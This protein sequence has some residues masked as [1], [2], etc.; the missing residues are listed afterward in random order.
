MSTIAL[1]Q[2]R[3]GSTRLPGK[4]LMDIAGQPMLAHVVE[5][6]LRARTLDGLVI[7]TTKNPVDEAIVT[8]ARRLGVPAFRGSEEDVLDRYYRAAKEHDASVIVRI[9]ADCPLIDP[10]VV[11]FVVEAFR[12]TSPDYASNILERTFPQ[13][14][15]T[16][17]VKLEAL[18]RAW[19]EASKAYQRA[20]VTPYIY[21]HPERFR[22]YSVRNAEDLS[23]HRWTVDTKEDLEFVRE[24]YSR[25][26]SG[27]R[28][29]WRDVLDLIRHEPELESINRH[30][31]QKTLEEG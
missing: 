26:G 15:D 20:H 4:V 31:R 16:E 1:V 12:K 28:F 3:M 21:E 7:A 30:V 9:T 29:G 24:V 22:L 11:D 10:T 25:L 5:R 6:S 2:A 13:G 27:G 19:R 18:E 8:E 17:V 14:L 23:S